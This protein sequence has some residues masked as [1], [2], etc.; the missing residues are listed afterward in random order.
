[1]LLA[2]ASASRAIQI[3]HLDISQIGRLPYQY[4]FVYTKLHKSWRK[5]K[6][7]PPPPAVSVSLFMLRIRT[8]VS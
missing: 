6:L 2:L 7:P 1:M 3:Q 4:K 8:C 5:G